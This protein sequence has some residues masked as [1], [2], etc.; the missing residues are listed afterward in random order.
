MPLLSR[1]LSN[2]LS[3]AVSLPNIPLTGL[4]GLYDTT[5]ITA[6]QWQDISGNSKHASLSYFGTGAVPR[7]ATVTSTNANITQAIRG[8]WT[9][10]IYWPTSIIANGSYTLFHVC[11][12]SGQGT[13]YRKRI[14]QAN[15]VNW[16]S[17]FW[18]GNYGKGYHNGWITSTSQ[19]DRI[20]GTSWRVH[21]DQKSLIRANGTS[22]TTG[23][24]SYTGA[25]TPKINLGSTTGDENSDFDAVEVIIY[26][27]VLSASDITTV[28]NYLINKYAIT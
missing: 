2:Y 20:S 11:R 21:T 16:L 4:I 25:I 28:E 7:L 1:K 17:G 19:T 6:T 12:Y 10:R 23:S 14:I 15:E 22:Y 9:S 5:S 27:T 26:N 3:S 24:S 13:N 18:Q 8:E